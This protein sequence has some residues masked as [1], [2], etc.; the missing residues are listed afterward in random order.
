VINAAEMKKWMWSHGKLLTRNQP[1]I[2]KIDQ[3]EDGVIDYTE[4]LLVVAR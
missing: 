4:F 3:K 2:D 1:L